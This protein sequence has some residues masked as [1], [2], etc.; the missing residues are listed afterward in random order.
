LL[1]A[2]VQQSN[3]LEMSDAPYPNIVRE[4]STLRKRL[5]F[6]C[7]CAD[8]PHTSNAKVFSLALERI[9][10][11]VP[12][13]HITSHVIRAKSMDGG[14]TSDI[15]CEDEVERLIAQTEQSNSFASDV[16]SHVFY[17]E[18]F[19]STCHKLRKMHTSKKVRSMIRQQH[20]LNHSE[21]WIGGSHLVPYPQEIPATHLRDWGE[22]WQSKGVSCDPSRID[23]L[24]TYRSKGVTE[25]QHGMC[26]MIHVPTI[27][28]WALDIHERRSLELVA[29]ET[30]KEMLTRRLTY[31]DAKEEL[32]K[33]DKFAGLVTLTTWKDLYPVDALVRHAL[34][35]LLTRQYKP[36]DALAA[37]KGECLWDMLENVNDYIC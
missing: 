13:A 8:D 34:C 10:H 4:K 32:E 9:P 21:S 5:L 2:D 27:I 1:R 11:L 37:Y 30:L 7:H 35:R 19:S 3:L 22:V 29:N 14:K 26:N 18:R 20:K 23:T 31:K 6:F 16:S 25:N 12:D 33:K 15:F 36:C 17:T 24:H 28:R